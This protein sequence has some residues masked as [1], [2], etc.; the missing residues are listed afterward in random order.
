MKSVYI[1]ILVIIAAAAF[2]GFK[3]VALAANQSQGTIPQS[4]DLC[5]GTG[6]IGEIMSV[7]SNT[8]T[9]KLND[10]G[11]KGGGNLIVNLSDRTTIETPTGFASLSNLKIRD[12]VTLV[13]DNHR[14]GTFTAD[15]VVVCNGSEAN[16]MGQATP[17]AVRNKNTEYTKVSGVINLATILFV[18]LI[19]LG[20]AAFLRRKIKKSLVYL[21][22]FTIFYIYLYK[23]LDYTLIQFQSLI[24]LKHFVPNL[25]LNGFRDGTNVNLI[26]LATLTLEDLKTSLLN[27][28]F[29]MPFGFGLPFITNF[30]M[31]RIVVAGLLF[32][33]VIEFLQLVTGFMANTTFRVADVNDLIF[34]TAGV[35]IGYMLFVGFVRIYRH[36]SRNWTISANPILR[37]IAERPQVKK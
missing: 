21:L 5:G 12:R 7:G 17:I 37:Y 11:E 8:F 6:G 3:R 19:W 25:M 26:P 23:V 35:A 27:I 24:L 15:A 13:G 31:K 16:G 33:I 28:L 9:L 29:M 22:F 1:I 10:G 2:G 18:G 32:S 34:N 30:R 36:I 14:D 20:I 4:G